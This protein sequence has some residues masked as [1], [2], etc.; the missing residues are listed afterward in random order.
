M[1]RD[2]EA[3]D[4]RAGSREPVTSDNAVRFEE[5]WESYARQIS[6]YASRHVGPEAAQEIVAETFLVAWRR[7]KDVPDDA[8][9]WLIVVARNTISVARRSERRA[10]ALESAL[11]RLSAS[12]AAVAAGPEVVVVEREAM[13]RGIAA[14]TE[15]EREALLLTSWDGLAAAQA[16]MV[17]GCSTTAFH[18]RLHRAR[19]RLAGLVNEG[20][21]PRAP[22]VPESSPEPTADPIGTSRLSWRY[23]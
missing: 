22:S 6:A 19:R 1:D 18:V 2:S 17:A 5:L 12:A 23:P 14:L 3:Q 4:G 16:A 8:L 10:H 9:P 20:Q 11:A 13:L 15:V 7:L 21:G